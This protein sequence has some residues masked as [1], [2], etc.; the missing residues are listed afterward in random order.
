MGSTVNAPEY[1][2]KKVA[3]T[4]AAGAYGRDLASAFHRCGANLLLSD[5]Q[6][7]C[8][9][10]LPHGSW[11]YLRADLST[12]A[13]TDALADWL[14]ADGVPDVLVNNAGLFPFVDLLATPLDCFDAIL[15]VNLR[16]P[17][18]LMQRV[19]AAMA[20]RGAG[21]ICNISSGAASVVRENG[22]VY[23]ASKAALEQLTRAF[24]VRLVFCPGNIS[25][26]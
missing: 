10:T 25:T 22:A 8:A 9:S 13:G 5:D 17:F 16:A 6:A 26:K 1:H 21:A 23:G 3:I 7:S 2:G 11:R 20:Q 24:A 15:G 14:L 12:A 19:G 4:G 18:R